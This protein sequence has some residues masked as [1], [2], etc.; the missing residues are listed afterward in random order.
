MK[1]KILHKWGTS[2]V[3]HRIVSNEETGRRLL[4]ILEQHSKNDAMGEPIWTRVFQLSPHGDHP[5]T[6]QPAAALLL[7]EMAALLRVAER[8]GS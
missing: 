2:T 6:D 3:E 5:D 7:E 4:L 8:R 1:P